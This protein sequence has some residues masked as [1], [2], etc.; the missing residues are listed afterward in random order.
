MSFSDHVIL[1]SSSNNS[2]NGYSTFNWFN[3]ALGYMNL[4]FL[5]GPLTCNL[6]YDDQMLILF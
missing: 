2:V 4:M 3:M 6:L 1:C 5:Y